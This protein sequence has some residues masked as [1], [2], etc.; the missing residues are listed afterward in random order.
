MIQKKSPWFILYVLISAQTFAQ[1]AP[2]KHEFSIQQC[3]DYASKNN[4]DVK[5]AMVDVRLQEQ[6]NRA[7][8]YAAYPQINGNFNMQYNP[9]V[10]VQTFPNFIAAGTY[11]VLV[12]EGVKNGSGETITS[13]SDFGIIQASFGTA[14]NA[15]AGLTLSQILFDGQVFVG[16]Q[17]RKTAIDFRQ[18]NVEFTQ[19]LIKTNISK[20]YYQ[21]SISNEQIGLLD[22][23]IGRAEKLLSDSR[24][25]YENGFGEKLDIDRAS[26]QLTNLQTQ[27]QT[28]LN[29]I[30]NGY[31]GLK[32]L[33]GMPVRDTLVLTDSVTDEVIQQGSLVDAYDYKD[34]LDFQYLSLSQK[35]NEFNV[36]RYKL[37]R[38]PTATLNAGYSKLSQGNNFALF[39]GNLWFASSYIGLTV[40]VPIVGGFLKSA[41]IQ[42]AQLE[43][44]KTNN[45]IENLKQ[46][47]D[48]EVDSAKNSFN[49]AV[50]TMGAQRK[51]MDLAEE[52]YNQTKKKYEIG[53]ASTTDISNAQTD[54]TTAQRNYI[55]AL[56]NAAIA[57]VDYL[58]AIGKL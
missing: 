27:K 45:N 29:S 19:E 20:I 6:Q 44:E 16:L 24:L 17:A 10:T 34:R 21:L 53:T 43:L 7:V 37:S 2:V 55:V 3:I 26:V 50:I 40:N 56:Y 18:K 49:N 33:M 38:I 36:R 9:N 47:I 22:A 4:T 54:L 30:S 25:L 58:R 5:N 15:N 23:N 41:N 51:N 12:A 48:Y 35:L 39:G 57:K 31:L 46:A 8:A 42:Q 28:A 13:P 32:V 11:G 1:Q 52:V 14:W